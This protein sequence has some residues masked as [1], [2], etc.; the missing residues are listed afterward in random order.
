[1]RREFTVLMG[2]PRSGREQCM[3]VD[4]TEKSKA[5]IVP[6]AELE[7]NRGVIAAVIHG[8]YLDKECGIKHSFAMMN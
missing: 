2:R 1:M 3:S 8:G 7:R 5:R 4:R 6:A